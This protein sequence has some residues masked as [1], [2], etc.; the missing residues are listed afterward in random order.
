MTKHVRRN[1]RYPGPDSCGLDAFA[2]GIN[3]VSGVFDD[4]RTLTYGMCF[5][6]DY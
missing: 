1:E 3:T 4:V 2:D 6:Q 5:F